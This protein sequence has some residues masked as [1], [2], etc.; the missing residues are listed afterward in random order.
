ML[1]ETLLLIR[2]L[3]C[4]D[5]NKETIVAL[6]CLPRVYECM[7][8]HP[9]DATTQIKCTYLMDTL[10]RRKE[11]K[12]VI[13]DGALDLT[14]A[15]M[16]NHPKHKDVIPKSLGMIIVVSRAAENKKMIATKAIRPLMKVMTDNITD[17][18]IQEQAFDLLKI[19]ANDDECETIV[20]KQ[21]LDFSIMINSLETHPNDEDLFDMGIQAVY[22]FVFDADNKARMQAQRERIIPLLDNALSNMSHKEGISKWAPKL[23]EAL[24]AKSAVPTDSADCFTGLPKALNMEDNDTGPS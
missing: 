13:C 20:G 12:V 2:N 18:R 10:G 7:K 5:D 14:L 23:R 8:R 19:L 24:N 17:A 9:N 16:E 3:G 21:F 6:G 4:Y 1:E 11:N 22:C 15:A